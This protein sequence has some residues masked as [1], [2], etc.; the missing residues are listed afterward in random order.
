MIYVKSDFYSNFS[1]AVKANDDPTIKGMLVDEFSTLITSSRPELIDVFNKVNIKVSEKPT[2]EEIVSAIANNLRTN[3]KLQAGLAYLVAKDNDI[4]ASAEK[5]S[6]TEGEGDQ[7]EEKTKQIDWNRSADTVTSIASTIG[8]FADTL[9]GERLTQFEKELKEKANTKS[10]NYSSQAYT[11]KTK[12][13][14]KKKNKRNLL[15][16]IGLVVV[17]GS[18]YYA[19]KKGMFSK[20]GVIGDAKIGFKSPEIK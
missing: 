6:R 18:I 1:N 20:K 3:K 2:N 14:P 19:Y 11:K 5:T 17:G 12:S 8:I 10:P 16:F 7:K 15:I 13:E 4:L 9:S